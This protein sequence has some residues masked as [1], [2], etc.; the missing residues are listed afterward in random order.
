MINVL[1]IIDTGGPGGAETVFLHT[2]TRLDPARFKSTAIVSRDGWLAGQL[3]AQ[4]V[5]PSIL[6]SQGSFNISY[7][8]GLLRIARQSR[9]RV[10]L[11]HLYGSSVYGCLLGRL[12]GLPVIAILHGQ[13]DVSRAGSFGRAKAW[14]VRRLSARVV[15][16]SSGLQRDLGAVLPIPPEKSLV[17]PNGVDTGVFVPGADDSIRKQ[18]QLPPGTLLVGAVGNIRRPKDY[19]TF[20]RAAAIL[21]RRDPRYQFVIAGEGSG[22]LLSSLQ[23]LRDELGLKGRLH[24]LGMRNDIRRVLGNL[25]V[26]VLS[27]TTEGFSIACIEAMACGVPVVATRSGGPQEIIESGT[28]GLLVPVGDAEAIADSVHSIA[29]DAV[30]ANGIRSG[31]LERVRARYSLAAMIHSYEEVITAAVG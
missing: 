25:D 29:T 1:N 21:A 22:E 26:F 2:T 5:T 17:I 3:R 27:S 23:M 12:L 30:K 19:P 8:K 10:V 20:I 31:A 6:P 18:L 9:A 14:V 15:F 7:L 13:T 4:G 11:A 16:V 24:L 28:S